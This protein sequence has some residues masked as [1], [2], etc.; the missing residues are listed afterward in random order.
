MLF[1]AASACL[2]MISF[3]EQPVA[4]SNLRQRIVQEASDFLGVPYLYA[5]ASS[6]GVDCSGLVYTVYRTA[7]E[8]TLPRRVEDLA[9]EGSHV[10]SGPGPGD[11]VFFD[12]DE[13]SH[14]RPSHVGILIDDSRFIHAASA[15]SR[16]GVIISS[17]DEDY[18]RLRYFGVRR[19][20][21]APPG[22]V[23]IDLS[24]E[25]SELGPLVGEIPVRFVLPNRGQVEG[26]VEFAVYR[27]E[28][29][30]LSKRTRVRT[31]DEEVS[32]WF[33]PESGRY[34]VQL[35][36]QDDKNLAEVNFVVGP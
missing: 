13:P 30:F 11:L 1:I 26:F 17:L 6:E 5:G 36:D 2:G 19:V 14:G 29:Y 33:V 34:T 25:S 23:T 3:A 7:A 12:T 20:I 4:S 8:M 28:S 22:L 35:K 27:N 9:R 24:R 32:L 31:Q 16:T 21:E 10:A 18:Y 15:G